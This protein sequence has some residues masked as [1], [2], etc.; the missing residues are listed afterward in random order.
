ME[1]ALDV[2]LQSLGLDVTN[3]S[4]LE[5]VMAIVSELL[6]KICTPKLK[7]CLS[8]GNEWCSSIVPTLKY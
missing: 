1:P 6:T 3:L 8:L 4:I 7:T 5:Q 2:K